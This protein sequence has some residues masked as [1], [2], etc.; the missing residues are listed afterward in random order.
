MPR[1]TKKQRWVNSSYWSWRLT[2]FVASSASLR[3]MRVGSQRLLI[4]WKKSSARASIYFGTVQ[5]LP[6]HE[7][8]KFY[9]RSRI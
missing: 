4:F 2:H 1:W 9:Y 7:T 8:G 6:W 5:S 3:R